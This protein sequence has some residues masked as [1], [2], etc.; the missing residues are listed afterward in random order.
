MT[1]SA[2]AQ[3]HVATILERGPVVPVIV[4]EDVDTE[5]EAA[6]SRA[7]ERA[8]RAVARA[9]QA[10]GDRRQMHGAAPSWS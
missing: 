5:P 10:A 2:Q 8:S 7:A 9:I 6:I 3:V 4:I 1:T